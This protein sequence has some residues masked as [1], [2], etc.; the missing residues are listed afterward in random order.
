M[1][2][3]KNLLICTKRYANPSI[4]GVIKGALLSV[5]YHSLTDVSGSAVQQ[6]LRSTIE[7]QIKKER[8]WR[9]SSVPQYSQERVDHAL[10]PNDQQYTAKISQ[11][12]V[13][14]VCIVQSFIIPSF[15][16]EISKPHAELLEE[17]V[18]LGSNGVVMECERRRYIM[19]PY[20]PTKLCTDDNRET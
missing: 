4:K 18:P 10:S 2:N 5:F 17:V 19:G 6:K 16:F 13:G 3:C 9:I 7:K 15:S 11:R 12:Q 20:S 8:R 14:L 1:C